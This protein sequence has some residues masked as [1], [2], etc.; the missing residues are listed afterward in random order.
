MIMR[1]PLRRNNMHLMCIL[2]GTRTGQPAIEGSACIPLLRQSFRQFINAKHRLLP[3]A[4][5]LVFINR[6]PKKE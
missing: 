2:S 3:D 5:F 6:D 4:F 1:L